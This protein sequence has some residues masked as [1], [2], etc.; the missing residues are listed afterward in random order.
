[1]IKRAITVLLLLG[2]LIL[3]LGPA[4]AA[5]VALASGDWASALSA[6]AP[7]SV[8]PLGFLGFGLL[9]SLRRAIARHATR[10]RRG[11]GGSVLSNANA[12]TR[13]D[14]AQDSPNGR[15]LPVVGSE[16]RGSTRILKVAAAD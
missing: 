6:F 11:S 16:P 4:A 13:V 7:L 1:L 3:F 5:G 10:G 15:P 12:R 2:T 14:H 8:L 9:S